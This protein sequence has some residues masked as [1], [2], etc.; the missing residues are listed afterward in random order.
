MDGC[1]CEFSQQEQT[2]Y[3]KRLQQTGIVNIE[4][5]CT[6]LASLCQKTGVKG[7]IICVALLDRMKGDQVT[8]STET[9]K[10]Y[11]ERPR[12]L[13]IK[14]L[15]KKLQEIQHPFGSR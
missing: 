3:I 7:A 5:E 8:I 11:Q 4:M 13:L 2:D 6:V 9:Y 12:A 1:I 10:S 15:R 14:Y